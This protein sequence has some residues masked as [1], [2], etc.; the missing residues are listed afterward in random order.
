MELTWSDP[1]L[2]PS[3][4]ISVLSPEFI[5]QAAV[6]YTLVSPNNPAAFESCLHSQLSALE[7][8]S[9]AHLKTIVLAKRA[10]LGTVKTALWTKLN[11][12][13]AQIA[14]KVDSLDSELF[15]EM[16]E[17][18]QEEGNRACFCRS[19]GKV[20]QGG[21]SLS[22]ERQSL[23]VELAGSD[24]HLPTKVASE[25]QILQK[26]PSLLASNQALESQI[27]GYKHLPKRSK[28]ASDA[29]ISITRK[30]SSSSRV[31]RKSL[32]IC[33]GSRPMTLRQLLI[34]IAEVYSSKDKSDARN[35]ALGLRIEPLWEHLNGY[36]DTKY[37][38]KVVSK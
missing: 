17:L 27:C 9:P 35:K 31:Q 18:V 2:P 26:Y 3:P 16:V 5:S 37:G 23:G 14:W 13:D 12:S 32:P 1:Y 19:P 11:P 8:Q 21:N 38:L 20:I 22:G 29:D 15:A 33:A 28:A 30:Q 34:L 7:S 36:L 25:T 10:L 6:L 24:T 4:A